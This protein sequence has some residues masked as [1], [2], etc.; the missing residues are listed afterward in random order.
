MHAL[1]AKAQEIKFDMFCNAHSAS[2][3]AFKVM[4]VG[5]EGCARARAHRTIARLAAADAALPARCSRAR[6][7]GR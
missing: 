4:I 1:H 5:V 7:A 3:D 2:Q 6:H